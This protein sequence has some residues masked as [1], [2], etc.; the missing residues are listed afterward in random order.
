MTKRG[1]GEGSIYRRK[2][3]GRWV[4]SVSWGHGP[5]GKSKRSYVYGTE[6]P[7]VQRR[8]LEL[9]R[10]QEKGAPPSSHQHTLATYLAEW[11]KMKHSEVQGKTWR[12]YN[13]LLTQHVIP[14]IGDVE[15]EKL[16]PDHIKLVHQRARENGLHDTSIH[17]LHTVLKQALTA[18]VREDRVARNIAEQVRPPRNSPPHK[19]PLSREQ[20]RQLFRTAQDDPLGALFILALTTGM[21]QGELLA[22]K[23]RE[24]D[25]DRGVLSV[26]GSLE[27][28]PREGLRIKEPKTSSSRRQ[29]SLTN[30]ALDALRRHRAEQDRAR[31]RAEDL[32][33]DQDLVFAGAMGGPIDAG[34]MMRRHFHPLL[35]KAGLEWKGG[36]AIEFRDLRTAAATLISLEGVNPKEVADLLGHSSTSITL[37]R[38]TRISSA[39]HGAATRAMEQILAEDEKP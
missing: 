17:H 31:A 20:A 10:E 9:L 30:Q 13:A 12:T 2:S 18:A 11:L 27:R 32:W 3:D 22:L 23:W 24:V 33:V 4:A 25:L 35:D 8:L 16:K 29:I 39:A 7:E 5:D 21:R 37:E 15:L 38:Y 6:K 14:V 19:A 28:V 34:N 26:V 36:P 1:Q